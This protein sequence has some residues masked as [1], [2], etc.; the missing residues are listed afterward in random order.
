MT[1]SYLAVEWP[2][3]RARPATLNCAM[4]FIQ[5]V[6]APPVSRQIAGAAAC[7]VPAR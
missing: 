6:A 5:Y 1:L 2:A 4:S 7:A 3:R